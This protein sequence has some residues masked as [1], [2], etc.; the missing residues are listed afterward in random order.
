MIKWLFVIGF[1]YS[2]LVANAQI[3]V[4]EPSKDLGDIYENKGK[5][6]AVFDLQNPYKDDT[7]QIYD[8]KTS[9]GCTAILSQDT[10]IYPGKTTELKFSYDPSG[11]TGLFTKSIEVLSRVGVY[12]QH[13]LLLKIT[14]NVV[15]EHSQVKEVNAELKEYLVAPINYYAITP[16]DT[17]YLDFNFFISFVNDL[18]YEID[19]FQFTNIGIE[20]GV[21][22]YDNLE[23]LEYLTKFTQQKIMREFTMRG[24]DPNT[25]FFDYPVF[26][27]RDLPDWATA[28][29][30]VYSSNFGSDLLTTSKI[31]IT[32]DKV[33]EDE[34]LVL[35]YERYSRPEPKEVIAKIDFDKLEGKLFL[36]GR[37]DL[38]GVVMIPKRAGGKE[39]KKLSEGIEKLVFKEIKKSSG[40]SKNEVS[41]SIDSI[42]RHPNDKYKFV[43]W[44]KSDEESQQSFTYEVKSDNIIPPLLPTYYQ[45]TLLSTDIDTTS[46]SFKHFWK[47]I[48]LN[49][50]SG[51]PIKLLIESSKS[52]IPRQGYTDMLALA[53]DNGNAYKA[54]LQEKFKKETGRDIDIKV[55]AYVHGPEYDWFNKRHADYSQYEYLNIIPLV[56]QK[57]EENPY[58][59]KPY[60]VNFDYFFNGIDTSTFVFKKFANYV[61]A[62]IEQKGFIHLIIESS[63]S[64]IQ[65]D[66]KKTNIFLAY[67]RSLESQNRLRDFMRKK[68]IDPNRIIFTEE[69][70]LKQ[71]PDY[72]GT[73][74][75]VKYRKFHYVKIIPEK[76]LTQ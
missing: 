29:I 52:N 36:N 67:E 38:K 32:D 3:L 5:V 13:R 49:H 45:S 71:G 72:D 27:E 41:I 4:K 69:R 55:E 37:L 51:K 25:V 2:G 46:Q 33:V 58:S 57:G 19:F 26:V 31:E 24:Y 60:M 18:S 34:S 15:G 17:S 66:R 12:D 74:P 76:Y 64:K 62:E 14:G 59:S 70:Y 53:R 1:I 22:N 7:I 63:I 47:N 6:I 20:V 35:N 10:L 8:V 28:S 43:M 42:I 73:I 30:K 50:K 21:N 56:H 75:V 54:F 48:I 39:V 40:V 11:R 65:I 68:L 23:Q 16:Y 44:D 61:A 9:C